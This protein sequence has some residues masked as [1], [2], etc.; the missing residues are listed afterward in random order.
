M[1]GII[2][3]ISQQIIAGENYVTTLTVNGGTNRYS[4]FRT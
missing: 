3:L 2:L 1:I 4:F